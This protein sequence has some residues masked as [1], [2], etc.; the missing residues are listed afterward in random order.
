VADRLGELVTAWTGIVRIDV[1]CP[2]DLLMSAPAKFAIDAAEECV[3]N[4]VRH[5]Q[6]SH[7]D[8]RLDVDGTDLVL[9]VEDNG[10]APSVDSAPGLGTTWMERVSRGQFSRT[11]TETG[12]NLVVM[13]VAAGE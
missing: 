9:C 8:V 11:R 13:R 1:L 7:I 5:A 3:A 4:A 10:A 12:T 6:A 2:G